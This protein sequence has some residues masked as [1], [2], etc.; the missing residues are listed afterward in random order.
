MES[1][2]GQSLGPF[3][4]KLNLARIPII[5]FR[6]KYLFIQAESMEH[7]FPELLNIYL[8]QSIQGI[9]WVS[10]LYGQ[11]FHCVVILLSRIC[12]RLTSKTPWNSNLISDFPC[13][14]SSQSSWPD[15]FADG[16]STASQM[17]THCH[18]RNF[19]C[20]SSD[21]AVPV[22]EFQLL[23]KWLRSTSDGTATAS[24][25]TT[26]CYW[27]NQLSAIEGILIARGSL[28][29][30]ALCYNPEGSW[31]DTR[32]V[33]WFLSIYLIPP[34]ALGPEVH[35]ASNRN[36]CQKQKSNVFKE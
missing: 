4:V 22:T 32:C 7:T 30:K 24:Q 14:R 2:F 36:K 23:L 15:T 16:T 27:W 28:V 34:A 11:R 19:N 10:E 6:S 9:K 8:S 33:E 12:L 31:F 18:W 26:L 17:T 13:M 25:M 21:C 3:A 5:Y 20:F 29:V 35:S 1:C